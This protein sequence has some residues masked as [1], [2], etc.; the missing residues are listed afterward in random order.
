MVGQ[1]R[2]DGSEITT[3]FEAE[4][5]SV[6]PGSLEVVEGVLLFTVGESLGRLPGR[7]SGLGSNLSLTDVGGRSGTVSVVP[8]SSGVG[9]VDLSTSFGFSGGSK[10]LPSHL[11]SVGPFPVVLGG[12]TTDPS[13][14]DSGSTTSGVVLRNKSVS[15]SLL[16]PRVDLGEITTP[17]SADVSS[18]FP[19]LFVSS[20][21]E[22]EFSV[23]GLEG[24]GSLANESELLVASEVVPSVSGFGLY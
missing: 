7:R 3:P 18:S 17:R 9:S 10:P 11:G 23:L 12:F 5:S 1:G 22:F 16:G 8:L 15:D 21:E 13:S 6:S 2:V 14:S 20:E 19:G 4:L 24:L